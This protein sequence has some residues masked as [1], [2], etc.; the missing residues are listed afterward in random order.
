MKIQKIL[1]ELKIEEKINKKHGIYRNEIEDALF[2]GKPI[3]YKSKENKYF[4]VGHKGRYIT[5]VFLYQKKN[6]VVVTAYPSSEWQIKLYKRK[7]K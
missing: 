3:F 1:I 5:I 6:A 7:K 4:A 2:E